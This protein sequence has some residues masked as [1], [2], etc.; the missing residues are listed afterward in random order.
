MVSPKTKARTK[1]VLTAIRPCL[2]QHRLTL[3]M[4][5]DDAA[6]VTEYDVRLAMC[7]LW[8]KELTQRD[9]DV[10]D[11]ILSRT[12]IELQGRRRPCHIKSNEAGGSG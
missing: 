10:I 3:P 2:D 5:H 11:A 8:R 12:C 7:R 6:I 4:G 9:I 1:A